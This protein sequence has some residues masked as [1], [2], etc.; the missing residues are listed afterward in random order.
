MLTEKH[1]AVIRAALRYMDEEMSPSGSEAMSHYLDQL[2]KDCQPTIDDV[3]DVRKFFDSVELSYALVDASGLVIE[4]K[5]LVPASL[6][7]GPS[8]QSDLS[9]IAA[10]LVPVS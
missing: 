8:F 3:T 4:S 10:V 7:G 1:L 9:L 2:G 6:E 5:L